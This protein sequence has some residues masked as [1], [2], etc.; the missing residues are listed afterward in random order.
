MKPAARFG[1]AA[2]AA[3]AARA[4]AHDCH[5]GEHRALLQARLGVFGVQCEEMCKR[6]GDYPNCQCPGFAGE[7]AEDGDTRACM[8]QHCQDPAQPCPSDPF[9][10]CVRER[11]RA[12]LLEWNDLMARVDSHLELHRRAVARARGGGHA[13]AA[14]DGSG[15]CEARS[16]DRLAMLQARTALFGVQCEEMCRSLGD[17]PN[18]QCPGFEG[19][20]ASDGDVRACYV[21]HCQDVHCP[22]DAFV[23]CVRET[24][25]VAALQLPH[26][27]RSL[28]LYA[29]GFKALAAARRPVQPPPS[30]VKCTHCGAVLA[31]RNALFRHLKASC[32]PSAGKKQEERERLVLAVG[33]LGSGFHG[34]LSQGP[35]EE[36][37]RP[38][39]EGTVL[40]AARRAW[41]DDPALAVVSRCTRTERGCH[42]AEN[43][44]VLSA[45]ARPG[46]RDDALRRELERS[47]VWL[48]APA[49][50]PTAPALFD[51][52]HA[53]KKRVYRYYIPYHVLLRPDELAEAR[54]S[55]GPCE[56][57]GIWLG[58]VH[59]GAAKA[60]PLRPL[61]LRP[62]H[63]DAVK[64]DLVALLADIGVTIV[65]ADVEMEVGKGQASLRVPACSAGRAVK[66][67]HGSMFMGQQIM[68]MPLAEAHAKFRVQKRVR[69]ALKAIRGPER[70]LRSFHNF[71]EGGRPGDPHVMRRLLRCTSGNVTEDLRGPRRHIATGPEGA[72]GHWTETDWTVTTFAATDFGPQQVRR[73][74]GA[75]AAVVR[76]AEELSYIDRA[77]A[78]APMPPPP[79]PAEAACLESVAVGPPGCD[80]RAA[81]GGEDE[82]YAEGRCRVESRVVE[83]AAHGWKEFA[84]H[85]DRG[86]TREH[87][88]L[89]LA[90]AAAAG[91]VPRAEAAL[92]AGALADGAN[93]YGQTAACLAAY[94]GHADVILMLAERGADLARPAHGG[95][96]PW[97]A[98]KARGRGAALRALAER[99][100]G[101]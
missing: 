1:A 42:A 81:V 28:D 72:S 93:E 73:M 94:G 61:L 89:E 21:Q 19:E 43:V 62:L 100:P 39:V 24:N 68:T 87:L 30:D 59:E 35:H 66:E 92:D 8:E 27:L 86:K 33:Y 88:N 37:A 10:T 38:T 64:A 16:H 63:E 95:A 90:E 40:A 41:G 34:L 7:P 53:S 44:L 23:T 83:E 3:L 77:F 91:D 36:A 99:L 11:T 79:A 17:Y 14:S 78:D 101:G 70:G 18:C 98:A 60:A 76:G 9:V 12:S 51:R 57:G 84:E 65:E 74:A 6:L 71:V 52:V 80:W 50:A 69:T 54:T 96:T 20:P 67:L 46:R 45:S 75:L 56:G 5:D 47:E 58:P 48:L 82:A 85:L 29:K 13:A 31:S 49:R 22:T 2:L 15:P 26:M 4:A 32:D 25:K 55:D 97:D